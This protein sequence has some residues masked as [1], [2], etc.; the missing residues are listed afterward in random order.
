MSTPEA[1]RLGR[2]AFDCR[3]SLLLPMAA[4]AEAAAPRPLERVDAAADFAAAPRD[5]RFHVT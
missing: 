1:L 5:T 3:F 2:A 4:I